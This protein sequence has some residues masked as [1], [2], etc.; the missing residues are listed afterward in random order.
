LKIRDSFH[1][2]AIITIVFWAIAYV[3]TRMA[4]KYFSAYSLGFLRYF[5][6]SFILIIVVI[7]TK[8]KL[9]KKFDLKWFVLGG[10]SGF[11]L[12]M[13]S[14]NKGCETVTASTSSVIIATVPIIT[15]LLAR[16]VYKE[17]LKYY[18]WFAII[19]SFSGVIVLMLLDGIFSINKGLIWLIL[20][21]V[22]LSFYNLMQRKL[23]RTYSALQASAFSIFIGTIMLSIFSPISLEEVK[24]APGIQLFYVVVMGVFSSAIAYLAWSQAF[25]KSKYTSSVS[26]YMFITPFLTTLLGLIIA[27]ERPDFSTIIGGIIILI[28]L[29]IFNFGGKF[30]VHKNK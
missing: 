7:A 30:Y 11:F 29:L 16:F 12:Y 25:A 18:Q 21:A 5:I 28:G 10:A 26:N 20:A 4:L 23:T 15:S 2:Y 3:F 9:P 13:I 22:L 17:R 19:I 6:A 14:F 24:S 27:K 1:I 8:M